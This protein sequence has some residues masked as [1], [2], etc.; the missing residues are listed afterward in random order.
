MLQLRC[1]PDSYF[2][3]QVLPL[4]CKINKLKESSRLYQMMKADKLQL[5]QHLYCDL[6]RCFCENQLFV[7]GHAPMRSTFMDIADCYGTLDQFHKVVS[8]LE[9]NDVAE[10]EAYN[11][12]LRALCKT[13]R[14]QDS[15]G[16]L[17]ELDTRGLVNCHSWNTVIT[18]FCDK[19]ILEEHLTSFVE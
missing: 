1:I 6:I 3:V 15:V 17:K 16:C 4:F 8:F 19:G 5:D 14:L 11:V 18:Q 7:S 13:G 2:Y 10:M 9:E 12:P